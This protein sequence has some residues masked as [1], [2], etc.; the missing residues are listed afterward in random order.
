MASGVG[1]NG[2]PG[3]CYGMWLDFTRCLADA[4]VPSECQSNRD[5][6]IECLHHRKEMGRMR[7]VADEVR[8][9]KALPAEPAVA[10]AQEA[11]AIAASPAPHEPTSKESISSS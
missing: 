4:D 7:A 10:T 2:G 9:R 6:Y 1:V 5:D 11:P 3:R 8:R